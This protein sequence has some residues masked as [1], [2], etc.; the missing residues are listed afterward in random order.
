MNTFLKKENKPLLVGLTGG[1]GSGKTTVA[2]ILKS[3]SV[4]VFNSDLEAKTIINNDKGIIEQVTIEFGAIYEDGKL[5]TQ[6]MAKLV[7]NDATA[8]EKLNNIIHPKVK[9]HFERWVAENNTA[10]ILIKEAAI[11]I[12]SGAYKELDKIILVTAPQSIRI[13][14]VMQRDKVSEEKI[15][16]RIQAQFSEEE[17]L[18]YADFVIKNNEE[19]LVIPQV[20]KTY[21]QIKSLNY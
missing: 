5:N 8:L 17:K 9:E 7:F 6:K 19:Q 13:Q 16:K 11:L 12:E 4:P 1:I 18:N 10:P 21:N 14:R 20:L 3:L 2:K 15:L